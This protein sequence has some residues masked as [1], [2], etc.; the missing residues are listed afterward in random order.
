MKKGVVLGLVLVSF[1]ISLGFIIADTYTTPIVP[2]QV[3]GAPLECRH[4]TTDAYWF[5]TSTNTMIGSLNPNCHLYEDITGE[6]CCPTVNNICRDNGECRGSGYFCSDFNTSSSCNSAGTTIALNS[7]PNSSICGVSKEFWKGLDVCYNFT[8]CKCS[9]S[10]TTGTCLSASNYSTKCFNS[11]GALVFNEEL[12]TCSWDITKKQDNCNS[13]K[14][15]IIYRG[16]AT[17]ISSLMPKAPK[18]AWCLAYEKTLLCPSTVKLSFVSN[19]S[20]VIGV[21]LLII[22]YVYL[23]KKRKNSFKKKSTVKKPTRRK[24]R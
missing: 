2:I 3:S 22:V 1:I 10:S 21:L 7:V 11:S 18:P 15:N 9:W 16:I 19:I 20:L 12:G 13:T 23:I 14:S 4:N 5:N 17:W 24:K 8:S 6:A